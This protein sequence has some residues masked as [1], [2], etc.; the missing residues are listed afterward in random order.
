MINVR[1]IGHVVLKVRD[2]ERSARFYRDV[3]GLREVARATFGRPMVF[4][5]ATGQQPVRSA[6]TVGKPKVQLTISAWACASRPLRS[7]EAISASLVS[8]V[9]M[10]VLAGAGSA[11][12]WLKTI[13]RR[14]APGGILTE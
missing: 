6:Q 13:T 2:L 1:T 3:L 9:V 12:S 10:A 11:L 4:F 14:V 8:K 7:P 5:S